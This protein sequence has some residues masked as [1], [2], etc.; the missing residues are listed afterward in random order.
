MP[1]LDKW[2]VQVWVLFILF[3]S[4]FS[5]VGM[6][7][8]QL[9]SD[10]FASLKDD[11]RRKYAHS[12]KTALQYIESLHLNKNYVFSHDQLIVLKNYQIWSLIELDRFEEAAQNLV[13]FKSMLPSAQS[14]FLE[15]GYYNLMGILLKRLQNYEESLEYFQQA[16]EIAKREN[17]ERFVHQTENN[18]G[19][20]YL[21]LK[22]C[23]VALEYFEDYLGYLKQNPKADRQILSHAIA[24]TSKGDALACLSQWEKA[25]Q[26]YQQV[27]VMLREAGFDYYAAETLV[28][29]A[30]VYSQL[31]QTEKI[32]EVLQEA[33][34]L[35]EQ[36][37]YVDVLIEVLLLLANVESE[38]GNAEMAE[39][40]WI[41]AESLIEDST[42]VE[43]LTEL[44]E[45]ERRFYQKQ[46]DINKALSAAD[47]AADLRLQQL[48]KQTAVN[49]AKAVAEVDLQAKEQ[50]ITRLR[51]QAEWEV[52]RSTAFRRQVTIVAVAGIVLLMASLL[53]IGSIRRKKEALKQTL[54]E[55]RETQHHLIESEKISALS[56][57][58]VGMAHQLN[59]P[60]GNILTSVTCFD[61]ELNKLKADV[62]DKK[63]SVK[64]MQRFLSQS[65]DIYFVIKKSADKVA[66]MVTRFKSIS[67]SVGNPEPVS[68]NLRSF[69]ESKLP[70][71]EGYYKIPIE[72]HGDDATLETY[73]DT[74]LKV[75]YM[76][77][78]N[79][80]EHAFASQPKPVFSIS[81]SQQD[82][83]VEIECKDNGCGIS[84]EQSKKIFTPFNTTRLGEG[85]LGLGL[86]VIY[87]SVFHS[88]NG[89]IRYVPSDLGVTFVIS[90]PTVSNLNG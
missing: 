75:L 28:N 53:F 68:I 55:L 36:Q 72:L 67:S 33:L 22:R 16:H 60:I 71:M 3:F 12:P 52:E 31:G 66:E 79:A 88:L 62:D 87:N 10:A 6:A 42:P 59:T 80:V 84:E 35:C 64:N 29:L 30:K 40:H 19:Q 5:E 47:L 85:K 24:L 20:L 17:R 86:N 2:R 82:K 18:I 37:N 51:E 70:L 25:L 41:R 54:R 50:K 76:L 38:N 73:P 7:Q 32:D 9:S 69:L 21:T 56:T 48:Q 77:L 49:L 13:L 34:H 61:E 39:A 74:L 63:L 15:Y 57:L 83:C 27:L 58:V 78:D 23:D 14:R 45:A 44:Y 65:T 8:T 1:S 89:R 81:I 43:L 90:L 46:G 26:V 11:I 4:V